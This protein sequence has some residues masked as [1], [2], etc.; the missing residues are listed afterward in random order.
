MKKSLL[1]ALLLPLTISAQTLEEAKKQVISQEPAYDGSFSY[2]NFYVVSYEDKKQ[3]F[4]QIDE[5]FK[6]VTSLYNI[7]L[8]EKYLLQSIKE[9]LIFLKIN[10]EWVYDGKKDFIYYSNPSEVTLEIIDKYTDIKLPPPPYVNG[11]RVDVTEKQAKMTLDDLE[12]FLDN[13]R[14]KTQTTDYSVEIAPSRGGKQNLYFFWDSKD[15]IVDKDKFDKKVFKVNGK[16]VNFIVFCHNYKNSDEKYIS[17]TALSE[18]GAEFVINQFKT[19]S[20]ITLSNINSDKLDKVKFWANGFTK[21][22]DSAGGDAL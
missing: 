19:N 3:Y 11:L 6:A 5:K 7:S 17:A 18:Q 22:W 21:A 9:E 10:L 4:T 16:N 13:I 1:L 8:K 12:V 20:W 14:K 15:C 2:K